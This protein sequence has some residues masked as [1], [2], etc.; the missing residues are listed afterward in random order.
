MFLEVFRA[1]LVGCAPRADLGLNVM[2]L[3][4]FKESPY[5]LLMNVTN[6]IDFM[7]VLFW[8]IVESKLT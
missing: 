8:G 5:L 1:P 7:F 2:T 6:A 4:S 3:V